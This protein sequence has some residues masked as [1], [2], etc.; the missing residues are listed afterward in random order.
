M[1]NMVIP[2]IMVGGSGTR[3]WPISRSNKPK[4]FLALG[5]EFSMFQNTVMRV[6]A[7]GFSR[8]WLLAN[9]DAILHIN[10]Q[11]PATNV[12]PAGVIVEP[13]QRGT[14]AAI[15][16]M[17]QVIGSRNPEALI[18]V[19]P[20]DHVISE[21]ELFRSAVLRSVPLANFGKI[22]TFGIVP[23]GPETRPARAR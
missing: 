9:D 18:L 20:A 19:M 21:P 14:A 1:T 11:L 23:T 6:R 3:L 8:P 5:S 17:V 13:V 7:D 15:A 4:Q 12:M 10:A 22:V 2:A 16:A